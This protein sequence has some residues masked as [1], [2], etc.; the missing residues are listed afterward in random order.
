[1]NF[2]GVAAVSTLVGHFT[3]NANGIGFITYDVD[4][5]GGIHYPLP[6]Q[7]VVVDGGREI[8]GLPIVPGYDV[9]CTLKEQ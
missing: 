2:G 9:I 5:G 7:F 1:M 3:L 6:I 4:A 8:R